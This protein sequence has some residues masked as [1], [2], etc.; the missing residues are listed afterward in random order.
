[1]R[2]RAVVA[3]IALVISLIILAIGGFF[4][5]YLANTL[6][7]GNLRINMQ[8]NGDL[9]IVSNAGRVEGP[10]WGFVV[11]ALVPV[12]LI[13]SVVVLMFEVRYRGRRKKQVPQYVT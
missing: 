13:A 11:I 6:F 1:M 10:L 9:W 8:S 5:L 12:A 7:G 3:L 2:K 4:F